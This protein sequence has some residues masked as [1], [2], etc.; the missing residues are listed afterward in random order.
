MI[1]VNDYT[2]I[3]D[4]LSLMIMMVGYIDMHAAERE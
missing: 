3:M 2:V 1:Q 4:T